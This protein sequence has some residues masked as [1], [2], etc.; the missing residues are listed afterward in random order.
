MFKNE[1]QNNKSPLN[2][3]QGTQIMRRAVLC[4]CCDQGP[5]VSPVDKQTV[6]AIL[7]VAA[8]H[9]HRY[10]HPEA[11]K[12]LNGVKNLTA[13]PALVGRVCRLA[14]H[15]HTTVMWL[16]MKSVFVALPACLP[17]CHQNW[18]Y[19]CIQPAGS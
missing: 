7:V 6:V 13:S 5:G 16:N 4:L 18:A 19:L 1:K 3:A 15:N 17:A 10:P 12:Q 8:L 9:T 2:L 11:A 14:Q